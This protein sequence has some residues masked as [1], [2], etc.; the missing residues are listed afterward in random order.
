VQV[1]KEGILPAGEGEESHRGG[2]ADV[3]T[4]HPDFAARGVFAGGFAAAGEERV[5][6]A[7]SL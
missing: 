1:A 4:D 7:A 2:Y 5:S 6:S 3:H